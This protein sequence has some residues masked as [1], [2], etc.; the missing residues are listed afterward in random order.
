MKPSQGGQSVHSANAA[1]AKKRIKHSYLDT[2]S[3]LERSSSAAAVDGVDN[4]LY[5][6]LCSGFIWQ[7][8]LHKWQTK[9]DKFLLLWWWTVVVP[10]T[11]WIV[12][13]PLV[14]V[15]SSRNVAWKRLLS[16]KVWLI[17]ARSFLV[18]I[19]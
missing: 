15:W 2:S 13:R 5:I 10:T 7:L 16:K 3:R 12:L 1:V 8:A 18:S 17:V 14:F 11:P 6:R 4:I 9:H 19:C